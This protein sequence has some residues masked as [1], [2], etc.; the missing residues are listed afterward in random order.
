MLL[1]VFVHTSLFI[2]TLSVWD[3]LLKHGLPPLRVTLLSCVNII[4]LPTGFV[5][6]ALG[7][8]CWAGLVFG[9]LLLILFGAFA[10]ALLDCIV[11]LHT[12]VTIQPG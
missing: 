12:L 3:L 8:V 4:F 10:L 9:V 7:F 11:L 5:L 6:F 2:I 1:Q